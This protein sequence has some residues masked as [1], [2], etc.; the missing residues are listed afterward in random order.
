MPKLAGKFALVTGGNSGIGLAAAR[1][2]IAEGAQVAITGRNPDTLKQAAASLGSGAFAVRADIT[3]ATDRDRLFSMVREKFGALDVLF[4]NAGM[5]GSTPLGSTDLAVF[6]KLLQVN[7]T[8]VFFTVQAALPLLRDGATIVL[9]GSVMSMLGG[10]GSS[11]YA[12][13]KA[14]VRAMARIFAAELSPRKIRVNIVT[15]GYTQT[16]LWERTRT[17]QQIAAVSERV[18]QVVPLGRWAD[19]EEVAKV[20]LFLA[21][22]DSSYIQGAE[23]IVDG[24]VSGLPAGTPAFRG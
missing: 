14:A 12:G 6:E 2:F 19:S 11:A 13:S 18:P 24:G 3:D 5:S 15:P 8:S 4:A 9:T 7:F 22:D 20:A 10:P 17:P 16:P 21:C 23:I 1:L